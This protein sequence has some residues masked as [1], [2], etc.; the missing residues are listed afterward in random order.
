MKVV[1]IPSL[2]ILVQSDWSI[3]SNFICFYIGSR[4]LE[5]YS[6]QHDFSHALFC[7]WS[8]RSSQAVMVISG[9]GLD[10]GRHVSL[11]SAL[12]CVPLHTKEYDIT[13][14]VCFSHL[15]LSHCCPF[16]LSHCAGVFHPLTL[17]MFSHSRIVMAAALVDIV[18]FTRLDICRDFAR[19]ICS[20]LD[21]TLV[22]ELDVTIIVLRSW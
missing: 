7:A 11:I 5:L 16:P 1:A 6:C 2:A 9:E 21:V 4:P 8:E 22:C 19:H 17:V 10:H 12:T 14:F 3:C 15:L 20:S 18:Q 13:I